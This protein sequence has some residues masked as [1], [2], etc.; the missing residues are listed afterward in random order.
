MAHGYPPHVLAKMPAIPRSANN[1]AANAY[2]TGTFQIVLAR[3]GEAS[4]ALV[5]PLLG[6]AGCVG[7]LT[8]EITG[9]AEGADSTQALA[10]IFAA[11]LAGIFGAAA[12]AD[13]STAAPR[14]ATGF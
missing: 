6:P 7:A 11:Q 1:A 2:R 10:S 9:G 12:E 8:A 5:A 3:T 4:G 14:A 13:V